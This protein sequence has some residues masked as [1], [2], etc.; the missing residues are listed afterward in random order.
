MGTLISLLDSGSYSGSSYQEG[1]K[2]KHLN[3]PT[4]SAQPGKV[5]IFASESQMQASWDSASSFAWC[6]DKPGR[7]YAVLPKLNEVMG[8]TYDAQ[9]TQSIATC[10]GVRIIGLDRPGRQHLHP[11]DMSLWQP[12]TC[13]VC[14]KTM[15]VVSTGST[16]S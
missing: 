10:N 1:K 12:A 6:V 13:A 14:G 7:P 16:A 3:P 5:S 9:T 8:T 15:L 2:A 11:V 4:P